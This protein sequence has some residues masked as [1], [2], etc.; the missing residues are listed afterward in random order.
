M[1]ATWN[2]TIE[3]HRADV[4]DSILDVVGPLVGSR[5]LLSLTMS[6]IAEASGIGRATLYRYFPDIETVLLAWHQREIGRHLAQ[7]ATIRDGDGDAYER[8]V[9]ALHFFAQSI[10]GV[11]GHPDASVAD[12]LH[13]DSGVR[14]AEERLR[15][16]LKGLVQEAAEAGDVRD[17][18][19]AM[20]LVN[21]CV[22]ALAGARNVRS[23][24]A[25]RR[26]VELTLEG[27]QHKEAANGV[28][29]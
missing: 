14:R 11:A 1:P 27:L 21:Y 24:A 9:R 26:L 25:V 28:S 12:V 22:S 3:T 20:E 19:P 29:R 15:A 18:V 16:L 10:R 8:L 6:A 17:D 7:L 5:G 13:R 23:A 4:H 2:E